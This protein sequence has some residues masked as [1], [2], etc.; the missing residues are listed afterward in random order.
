[1]LRYLYSL[2]YLGTVTDRVSAVAEL[3]GIRFWT[4][5]DYRYN[6]IFAPE[7]CKRQA[8]EL[9]FL[10][11]PYRRNVTFMAYVVITG[12]AQGKCIGNWVLYQEVCR[13]RAEIDARVSRSILLNRITGVK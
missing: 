7:P 4:P 11:T 13:R 12:P 3:P 10:R 1:M 6:N 2:P 9:G 5:F 8:S